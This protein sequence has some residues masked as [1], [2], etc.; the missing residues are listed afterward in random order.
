MTVHEAPPTTLQGD[1]IY[2][3]LV[4][5]A[6]FDSQIATTSLQRSIVHR[7]R[8]KRSVNL[9]ILIGQHNRGTDT[10]CRHQE[11]SMPVA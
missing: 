6:K 10:L 7:Y 2:C 8:S 5:F 1:L 9:T 3:A 11:N 4:R